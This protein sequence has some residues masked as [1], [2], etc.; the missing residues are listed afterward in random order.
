MVHYWWLKIFLLTFLFIRI[1]VF[2][3][4]KH[5]EIDIKTHTQYLH[6]IFVSSM[7]VWKVSKRTSNIWTIYYLEG[8]TFLLLVVSLNL[9][10]PD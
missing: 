7:T 10:F 3:Y 2:T 9:N 8:T 6:N 4:I 1:G 5:F